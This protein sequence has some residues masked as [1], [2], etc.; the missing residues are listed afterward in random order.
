MNL[1][2]CLA[3]CICR[4]DSFRS[5]SFA[6]EPSGGQELDIFESPFHPYSPSWDPFWLYSSLSGLCRFRRSRRIFPICVPHVLVFFFTS[7]LHDLML[8]SMLTDRDITAFLSVMRAVKGL[9]SSVVIICMS[10]SSFRCQA[11]AQI[12]INQS[13]SSKKSKWFLVC[14]KHAT[15]FLGHLRRTWNTLRT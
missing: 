11:V 14:W 3:Q 13:K 6:L 2:V 5:F 1:I 4:P 12:I 9:C 7:R 15:V 10:S 8:I